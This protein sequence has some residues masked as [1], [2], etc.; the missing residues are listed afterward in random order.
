MYLT[1]SGNLP[2]FTTKEGKKTFGADSY[3]AA[4]GPPFP[5]VFA[6]VCFQQGE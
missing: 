4:L 6:C 2:F 1:S 3:Q 5:P